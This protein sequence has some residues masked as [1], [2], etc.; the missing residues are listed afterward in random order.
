MK[1]QRRTYYYCPFCG[2]RHDSYALK[3]IC[4][5]LC[6]KLLEQDKPIYPHKKQT[7]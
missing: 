7:K 6:A 3:Q 5:Q 2:R 4:E 1:R